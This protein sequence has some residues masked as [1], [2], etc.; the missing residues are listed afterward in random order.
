M[1][2]I[3]MPRPRGSASMVVG[4][5]LSRYGIAVPMGLVKALPF[6][7]FAR[8]EMMPAYF[9]A[10]ALFCLAVPGMCPPVGAGGIVAAIHRTRSVIAAIEG[11]RTIIAGLIRAVSAM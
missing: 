2:L 3:L 8:F 11:A 4:A 10:A 7:P 1:P 9:R 5:R 6:N